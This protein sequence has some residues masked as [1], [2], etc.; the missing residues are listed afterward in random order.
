M[1]YSM[2]FRNEDDFDPTSRGMQDELDC[3]QAAKMGQLY[4]KSSRYEEAL[5]FFDKAILLEGSVGQFYYYRGVTNFK[6]GNYDDALADLERSMKD[7]P[8]NMVDIYN[9]TGCI[10]FRMG[11]LNGAK[12][13]IARVLNAN[14]GLLY[15][16]V[17]TTDEY[18]D[19]MAS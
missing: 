5:M 4:A 16:L 12:R 9:Y 11:D 8:W 6:L 13:D 7:Q 15:D 18:M 1:S 2:P 14:H 3:W 10:R 17:M 19:L